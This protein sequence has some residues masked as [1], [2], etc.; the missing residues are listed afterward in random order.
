VVPAQSRSQFEPVPRKGNLDGRGTA[1]MKGGIAAMAFAIRALIAAGFEP[2]GRLISVSVPDEE[3]SGLAEPSH[4]Q[5]RGRSSA[6][7]SVC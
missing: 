5:R 7:P 1:D 3:T 4:W 2:K 6:T